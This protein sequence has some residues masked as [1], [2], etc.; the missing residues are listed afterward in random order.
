MSFC[1]GGLEFPCL[2]STPLPL[3]LS[4]IALHVY[5][6]TSWL[7]TLQCSFCGSRQF[8]TVLRVCQLAN[9][10]LLKFGTCRSFPARKGDFHSKLA[11]HQV[12][13]C[14]TLWS[15]HC[16]CPKYICQVWLFHDGIVEQ[17]V[18]VV[19]WAWMLPGEIV[20]IRLVEKHVG[21]AE[22]YM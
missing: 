22:L 18:V 5:L 11:P 17:M 16:F 10:Q 20:L 2:H 1:E 3:G 7:N 12:V 14:I 8:S 13:I 19:T 4:N 9:V 6:F 15:M 21:N